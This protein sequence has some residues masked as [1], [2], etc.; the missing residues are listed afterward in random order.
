MY[1]LIAGYRRLWLGSAAQLLKSLCH[2]CTLASLNV[3]YLL[4]IEQVLTSNSLKMEACSAAPNYGALLYLPA[5]VLQMKDPKLRHRNCLQRLVR[6][7]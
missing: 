2:H 5:S 6:L 3:V 7:L 4:E 1:V